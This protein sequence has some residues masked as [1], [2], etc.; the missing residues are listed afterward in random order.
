MTVQ[1]TTILFGGLITF[2]L[3]LV[4]FILNSIHGDIKEQREELP[5]VAE[6]LRKYTQR[7]TDLVREESD[8]RSETLNS[9]LNGLKE[10]LETSGERQERVWESHAKEHQ[11][12][13]DTILSHEG[14][15]SL[16][17]GVIAKAPRKRAHC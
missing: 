17:E 6:E 5:R 8:R 16:V 10:A 7:A 4:G 13:R 9:T 3:A 14:R 12:F 1:L 2:L 15:I 11:T